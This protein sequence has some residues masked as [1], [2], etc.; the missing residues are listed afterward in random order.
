MCLMNVQLQVG[1]AGSSLVT[2]SFGLRGLFE[3]PTGSGE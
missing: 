2:P 1:F 3:N